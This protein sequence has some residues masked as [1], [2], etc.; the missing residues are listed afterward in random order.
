RR[1]T[2]NVIAC[3]V[4]RG[5]RQTCAGATAK[6]PLPTLLVRNIIA[7][8]APSTLRPVGGVA[9]AGGGGAYVHLPACRRRRA[10]DQGRAARGR[11]RP[12]LR[13]ARGAARGN[14]REVCC[15]SQQ[16]S[17]SCVPS[18][19][20]GG[21]TGWGHSPPPHPSPASGGGSAPSARNGGPERVFRLAQ[22]RQGVGGA[23][24]RARRR[25]GAAIGHARQG[26]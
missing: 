6:P 24:S 23:R 5:G 9:R 25:Q 20:C 2:D 15:N 22:P 19:A 17:G 1:K 7:S 18:P 26:R 16:T 13:Q 4:S 10:R 12:L 11:L 21:G 3:R 14:G 8:H